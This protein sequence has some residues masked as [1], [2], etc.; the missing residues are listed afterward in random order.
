MSGRKGL[1][2][3]REGEASYPASSA[4]ALRVSALDLPSFP[5]SSD[6]Q[7]CQDP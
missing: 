7:V 1:S 3:H 6:S 4:L 5:C 2:A